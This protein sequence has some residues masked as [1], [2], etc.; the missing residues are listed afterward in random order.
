[1]LEAELVITDKMT[2]GANESESRNGLDP[3]DPGPG[4]AV[5]V[6]YTRIGNINDAK[7]P[8]QPVSTL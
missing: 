4:R 5:H 1:M 8:V 6:I 2:Q 3:E 7:E